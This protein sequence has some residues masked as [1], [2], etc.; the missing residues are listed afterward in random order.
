MLSS[1]GLLSLMKGVIDFFDFFMLIGNIEVMAG[2][3]VNSSFCI[4]IFYTL[5]SLFMI[6]VVTFDAIQ[7]HDSHL[8]IS[9]IYISLSLKYLYFISD[10]SK[11]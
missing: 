7:L 5:Q 10:E 6:L 3:T 2:N 4:L 8:I 11:R 1:L 9:F